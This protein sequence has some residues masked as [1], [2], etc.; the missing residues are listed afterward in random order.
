MSGSEDIAFIVG[1]GVI[2]GAIAYILKAFVFRGGRSGARGK[3]GR[4]IVEPGIGLKIVSAVMIVIVCAMF[5]V[6]AA[7]WPSDPGD[8]PYAA[9]VLVMFGLLGGMFLYILF[10]FRI[11]YDD[12]L[13]HVNTLIHRNRQVRWTSVVAVDHSETWDGWRIRTSDGVRFWVY[14]Y[15]TGHAEFL[16]TAEDKIGAA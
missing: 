4:Q 16:Q 2:G 15:L 6:L 1:A 9:G 8:V 7:F 11:S 3:D 10:V 12:E 14:S 13:I 5:V